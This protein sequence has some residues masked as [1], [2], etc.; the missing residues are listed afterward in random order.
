MKFCKW[1]D[2]EEKPDNICPWIEGCNLLDYNDDKVYDAGLYSN[3]IQHSVLP[4]E[5]INP[6]DEHLQR[7]TNQVYRYNELVL[8]YRDWSKAGMYCNEEDGEYPI[9]S[10]EI[11]KDVKDIVDGA[12]FKMMEGL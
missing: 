2:F 12:V 6:V 11:E 5:Y 1:Y 9:I 8:W 4:S 10:Q 7:I 3:F